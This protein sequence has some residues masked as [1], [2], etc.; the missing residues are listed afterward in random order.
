MDDTGTV[1]VIFHK[2]FVNTLKYTCIKV[3]QVEN[4][5]SL[6]GSLLS[7]FWFFVSIL[8]SFRRWCYCYF[9]AS[10]PFLFPLIHAWRTWALCPTPLGSVY[11]CT[12]NWIF[13]HLY[14][15]VGVFIVVIIIAHTFERHFLHLR[16]NFPFFLLVCTRL[17]AYTDARFHKC[18]LRV[19][20][21]C[22][23]FAKMIVIASFVDLSL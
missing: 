7:I 2:L 11:V 21:L 15:V 3:T 18:S 20:V 12:C 10:S 5:A 1:I 4:S 23:P 6:W 8:F 22:A 19:F 13:N 17:S 14:R 16:F 9:S